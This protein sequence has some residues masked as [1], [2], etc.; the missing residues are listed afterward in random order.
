MATAISTA[1]SVCA[2]AAAVLLSGVSTSPVAAD[3][4]LPR[5]LE[6]LLGQA[7]SDLDKLDYD[8]AVG[9]IVCDGS[10][11]VRSVT[12]TGVRNIGAPCSP[13]ETDSLM[14]SS[15]DGHLIWCPPGGG[16]WT[17]YRP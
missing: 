17:L 13:G 8:P 12:P 7:C 14:A 1:R 3:P 6:A 4:L 16:V 2:V 15:T 5:P 9:Q 10:S 11:W